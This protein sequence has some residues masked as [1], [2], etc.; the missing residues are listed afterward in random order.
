MFTLTNHGFIGNPL[1]DFEEDS[2]TLVDNSNISTD[3][4]NPWIFFCLPWHVA[5]YA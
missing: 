5:S 1:T 3:L 4:L 2:I